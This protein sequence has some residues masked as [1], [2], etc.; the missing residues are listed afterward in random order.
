MMTRLTDAAPSG[1]AH[2]PSNMQRVPA[3]RMTCFKAH[4]N[5]RGF[6]LA[7]DALFARR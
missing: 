2:S 5:P 3:M 7:L 6:A 4:L 1:P